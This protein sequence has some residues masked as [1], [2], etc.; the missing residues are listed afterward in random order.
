MQRLERELEKLRADFRREVGDWKTQH[1]RAVIRIEQLKEELDESRG[2]VHALQDKLFGR[3]SE[4][5]GQSNRSNE[6]FD[7]EEVAAAKKKRGAQPGHRGHG[8]RDY[9][10][11]PVVEEFVSLPDESLVCPT[12]LPYQSRTFTA[13]H[14]LIEVSRARC[15]VASGRGG[16]ASSSGGRT[17]QSQAS[18]TVPQGF[19]EPERTLVGVHAVCGGL[20]HSDGQQRLGTSGPVVAR[21]NF[22]G[23]GSLW[24]GRLAA[25]MF[26]LLATLAHWTINPRLWLL[27]Y[28]E[29][30]A[31]EGGRAPENIQP[32]LPWNLSDERRVELGDRTESRSAPDTS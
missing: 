10:H 32:F 2:Q 29:S 23:S 12:S 31:A 9:S 27:W 26:S 20:A 17:L 5:S 16:D 22:Y 11:L 8:R 6:L 3:K 13:L 15:F 21:K 24:S 19:E 28:L 4:K 14:R 25:M 18:P 7:P 30:C 1:A